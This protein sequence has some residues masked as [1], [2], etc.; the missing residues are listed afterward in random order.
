VHG[1]IEEERSGQRSFGPEAKLDEASLVLDFLDRYLRGVPRAAAEEPRVRAFVMGENRWLSGN[2]WPLPGTE[3]VSLYLAPGRKLARTP[4]AGEIPPSRFVS[5]PEHPVVDP[6]GASYGAHDYRVLASRKDVLVFETEPLPADWR[7]LGPVETEIHLSADAPDVDLWVK[8]EDVAPDG[9]AWNLSSPGTDVLRASERDG[10]E[11]ELLKPG[12]IA[13]I[14]LPNL[15]TGNRFAKGHRVR[16]VLCGSFLPAFSRNPQTGESEA[17]SAAMRRA[18]VS[19]HHDARYPSRI[20]LPVL[21]DAAA[22][23]R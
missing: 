19:I 20:V 4:P 9:T 12:E 15:R 21:P 8:L 14:R 2:A 18:V 13:T 23:A 7:V 11:G 3:S 17:K 5:D 22:A 10:K 6:N 1:G 16:V